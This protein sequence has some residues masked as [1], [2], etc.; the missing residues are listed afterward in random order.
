MNVGREGKGSYL[1]VSIH[2][3]TKI[4]DL[5]QESANYAGRSIRL[6]PKNP[7]SLAELDVEG[8]T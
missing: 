4:G 3:I 1:C 2:S 6:L 8:G 5:V 7:L